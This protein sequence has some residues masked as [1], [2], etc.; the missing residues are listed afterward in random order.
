MGVLET[1]IRLDKLNSVMGI[2]RNEWEWCVADRNDSCRIIVLWKKNSVVVTPIHINDQNI[3]C[4]ASSAI[5]GSS[6]TF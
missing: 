4:E 5:P 2:I 3:T 6:W 1:E